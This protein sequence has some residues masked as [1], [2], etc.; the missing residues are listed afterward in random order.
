MVYHL[1]MNDLVALELATLGW[2]H[3]DSMCMFV[4]IYDIYNI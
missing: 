1:E 4:H 2:T 3:T